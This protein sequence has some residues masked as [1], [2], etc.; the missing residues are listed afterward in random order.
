[1]VDYKKAWERLERSLRNQIAS[2]TNRMD[3]D[4]LKMVLGSMAFIE[5]EASEPT[6][7]TSEEQE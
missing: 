7:Q 6:K 2:R 4:T 3:K 1:M 5:A